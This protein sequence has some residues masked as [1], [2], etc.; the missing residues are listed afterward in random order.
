MARLPVDVKFPTTVE[1]EFETNPAANVP[2]PVKESVPAFRTP[3][4][5]VLALAVV[6]VEVVKKPVVAV[7]SE[8]DALVKFVSAVCVEEALSM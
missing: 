6:E 4:F 8:D 7:R 3:K 5:A 1:D 2:R